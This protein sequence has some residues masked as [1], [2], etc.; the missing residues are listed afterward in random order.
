MKK[1]KLNS[2]AKL[3][4]FLDVLNKREDGYHNIK[5]VMQR[6]SLYDKLDISETASGIELSCNVPKIPL[7]EKNTCYTAALLIKEKFKIDTGVKIEINKTIPSEAGLAGG[8]SNAAAVILAL[9][10][11]WD[12]GMTADEMKEIGLKVGA[13]L[14]FCLKGGTCLCEGLG[15]IITELNPFIWDNILII[16]PDFS[17]STPL[18]YKTLTEDDHNKYIDNKILSYISSNNY[19]KTCLSLANTLEIAAFKLH[20]EIQL[21]KKE[22]INTGA[23]SS[24]MTGSGSAVFACFM[25]KSSITKAYN[26]L[27]KKYNRIFIC[28][29]VN[30]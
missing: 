21:I 2:Y 1:I 4:L 28:K 18:A 25:D 12:L 19:Y 6:V 7:D 11:L 17:I 9:N 5:S 10:K 3:N 16:K 23:I 13:D 20:P 24:L 14:A 29:T 22:L 27:L 8:S 30:K 15:D 26:I